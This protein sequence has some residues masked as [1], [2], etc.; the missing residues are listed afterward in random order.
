MKLL[1]VALLATG[2]TAFAPG[3]HGQGAPASQ[4]LDSSFVRL[5]ETL[6]KLDSV[7]VRP[8]AMVL[9]A[10]SLSV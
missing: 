10:L 1:L 2:G 6:R 3:V 7:Y 5:T 9:P 4:T 8:P